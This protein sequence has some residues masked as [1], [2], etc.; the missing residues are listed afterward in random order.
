MIEKIRNSKNMSGII[1]MI[2]NDKS[3]L[4]VVID[5]TNYLNID[6]P[7]HERLF[8][9]RNDFFRKSLCPICQIN[10]LEW[11]FKYKKYDG[12]KEDIVFFDWQKPHL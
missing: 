4:N 2:N 3:L 9:I 7:I 5:R 8:N 10:C 12:S 6:V 11:N 1:R